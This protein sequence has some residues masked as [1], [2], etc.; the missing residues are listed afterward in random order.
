MDLRLRWMPGCK[1]DDDSALTF[2]L[3]AA[4]KDVDARASTDGSSDAHSLLLR[5]GTNLDSR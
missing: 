3:A 2:E 4:R 5:V 1:L